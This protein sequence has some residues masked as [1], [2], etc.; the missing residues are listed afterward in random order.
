MPTTDRSHLWFTPSE[1][2]KR[3]V[4]SLAEEL[5]RHLDHVAR[6]RPRAV[7]GRR[8][9][10]VYAAGRNWSDYG[11]GL[12]LAIAKR[13]HLAVDLLQV[14][15]GPNDGERHAPDLFALE[16]AGLPFEHFRRP[17]PVADALVA[18]LLQHDEVVAVVVEYAD[19]RRYGVLHLQEVLLP[20]ISDD[21]LPTL[22]IVSEDALI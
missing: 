9:R 21:G 22:F 13:S 15:P 8:A 1:V 17:G 7:P 12:I 18:H 14:V 5:H 16:V 3:D 2:A 4:D 10:V 19:L 11:F 20:A 6:V